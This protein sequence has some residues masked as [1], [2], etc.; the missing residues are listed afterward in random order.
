LFSSNSFSAI[1]NAIIQCVCMFASSYGIPWAMYPVIGMVGY[2]ALMQSI[3]ASSLFSGLVD[4]EAEDLKGNYSTPLLVSFLYLL[5]S[6]QVYVAGHE[7]FAGI[8]FAHSTIFLLTNLLG[9]VK[10]A[11]K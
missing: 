3:A 10:L 4:V 9:V 11:T 5:S 6:Y 7:I 1:A 8:M 2:I